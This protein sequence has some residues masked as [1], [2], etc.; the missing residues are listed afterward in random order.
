VVAAIDG[1]TIGT[2]Y[3]HELSCAA[4]QCY[5]ADSIVAH[6]YAS[7]SVLIYEQPASGKGQRFRHDD[8][9]HFASASGIA[10]PRKPLDNGDPMKRYKNA[11]L[12]DDCQVALV[13]V[14]DDRLP[15]LD[16]RP[17]NNEVFWRR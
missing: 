11:Q 15:F 7:R 13:I 14:E 6:A 9:R 10:P 2:E 16:L 1:E 8:M 3:A 17:F 12:R 5:G 4:R